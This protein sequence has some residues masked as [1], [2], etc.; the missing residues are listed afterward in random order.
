M[1]TIAS[2]AVFFGAL[3]AAAVVVELVPALQDLEAWMEDRQF[4][5]LLVTGGLAACGVTLLVGSVLMMMMDDDTSIGQPS[6]GKARQSRRWAVAREFS[7][8]ELKDAVSSGAAFRSRAW[9]RPFGAACGALLILVGVPGVIIVVA[10]M[11]LKLLV[12]GVLGYALVRLGWG[13]A[14]A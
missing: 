6:S 2:L 3:F 7:F 13:L 1:K 4:E 9:T 14:K 12:T 11:A 10:P 5:L 8:R